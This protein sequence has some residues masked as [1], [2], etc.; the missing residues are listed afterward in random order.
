ME[1]KCTGGRRHGRRHTKKSKKSHTRRHGRRRHTLRGGVA[2]PSFNGAVS[3]ANGQPAGPDYSASGLSGRAFYPASNYT[4]GSPSTA[5]ANGYSA[6]GGRRRKSGK[7]RRKSRRGMRGGG[8]TGGGG[9][10]GSR[11]MTSYGGESIG[12]SAP[13]AAV[14]GPVYTGSPGV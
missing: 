7:S 5:S 1:S 3:G 10:F 9:E 12:A 14:R 13:G 2:L 4:T 8:G 11:I 6:L